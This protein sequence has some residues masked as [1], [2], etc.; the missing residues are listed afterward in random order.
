[1]S[2]LYLV[3]L[4]I[5]GSFTALSILA[6]LVDTDFDAHNPDFDSH[7]EADP[8][9]GDS[10][11]DGAEDRRLAVKPRRPSFGLP[12]LNLRFW[13]FGGCFFGLTGF[14]LLNLEPSLPQALIAILA[15]GVGAVCGAGL[16]WA[17]RAL[18]RCQADSLVRTH[19]VVGLGGTVEI[20]FDASRR[21]KVRLSVKGSIIDFVAYT[22]EARSFAKGDRIFVVSVEAQ[23]VWVVSEHSWRT[24]TEE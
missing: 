4:I 1:M 5:G 7:W 16:V 19:D 17:M 24:I 6:G 8:Q 2:T 14:L 11:R 23:K 13:T 10:A 22:E 18:Q 9:V 15:L 3:C 21:G 20:P 12:L